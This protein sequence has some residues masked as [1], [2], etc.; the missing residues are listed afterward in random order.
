MYKDSE[1]RKHCNALSWRRRRDI[2]K[3]KCFSILGEKCSCGYSDIRALV[4]D[5]IKGGGNK[6]RD[7]YGGAYWFRILEKIKISPNDYQVL[8]SNCNQIK[9][10]TFENRK[11]KHLSQ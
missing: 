6:E 3:K 11:R 7:K 1:K 2:A 10:M 4:I 9:R 5:H 8:C